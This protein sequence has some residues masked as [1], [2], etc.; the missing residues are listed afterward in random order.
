M[1]VLQSTNAFLFSS[2][3]PAQAAPQEESGTQQSA[4]AS[5]L[6][7][8][9]AGVLGANDGIVSVAGLVIGVAAADPKN[10]TAILIAGVAG[11]LAGAVSMAAGEYV[12]V[13]TQRDSEKNLVVKEKLAAQA[14]PEKR[15]ERLAHLYEEKGLSAATARAVAQ[16][17]TAHDG[18]AAHLEAE[19]GLR[20]DE[21]SNPWH[22]A[23]SSA[24]AFTVGA[25]LPIISIIFLPVS[26]K[27]PGTFAAVVVGLG[28][29]G[30]LSAALGD[31]PVGRA[32]I[33]LI[34][35]GALAMAVTWGIGHLIG[36][37]V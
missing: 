10:S 14:N 11:L 33:R 32:V 2:K 23:F 26:V 30:W 8:L 29:A 6:N 12:S 9:R 18:V 34:S 13:S 5:R 37:S 15:L 21:Y 35:G 22:A 31:A 28:L 24:I 4:L 25:L 36:V 7:W 20:E 3:A 17:L 27:I 16:E 19:Y 1:T